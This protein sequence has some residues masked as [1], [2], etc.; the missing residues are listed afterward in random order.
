MKKRKHIVTARNYGT[1]PKAVRSGRPPL[2][3]MGN[4]PYAP[5][6]RLSWFSNRRRAGDH[7]PPPSAS[8]RL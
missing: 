2:P 3:L 8:S 1:P 4:D 5:G 7:S 6:G